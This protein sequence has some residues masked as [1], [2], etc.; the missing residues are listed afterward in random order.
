MARPE[1]G[2]E[3]WTF[4]FD[5]DYYIPVA[6]NNE[7]WIGYDDEWSITEKVIIRNLNIRN[8]RYHF[9]WM[10]LQVDFADR[11]ELGGMMIWS[12]DQDDFKNWCGGWYRNPIGGTVRRRLDYHARRK[13]NL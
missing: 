7:T 5:T 13:A 4:S 8:V 2:M 11:M 6:F 1:G 12:I 9:E 3:G 10:L